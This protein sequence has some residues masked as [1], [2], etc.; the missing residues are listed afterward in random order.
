MIFCKS[1]KSILFLLVLAPALAICQDAQER[2]L[3]IIDSI[4]VIEDPKPGHSP[5]EAQI[6][7]VSVITDKK[8]IKDQFGYSNIDKVISIRTKAFLERTDSVKRIPTTKL[9]IKR[10]GTWFLKDSDTPYTGYFIDYFLN[11]TKEGEGYFENGRAK[12]LRT[13][14][15]LNGYKRFTRNYQNG[16]EN[17][18]STEYF[19]N[20]NVRMEGTT[21]GGKENG[22]WK[23]WYSTGRLKRE[24]TFS[25]GNVDV[26]KE[27]NKFYN[28]LTNGINQ[29]AAGNY[30]LA[31]KTL[32]K[33]EELNS[34]YSDLYFHRG[35]AFFMQFK[36][37]QAIADYD[38]ALALE[39]LYKE[40]LTNRAFARIRKHE[41]RDSRTLS[42]T[43][44]TTVIA[45]KS[46]TTIPP[47]DVEKICS[48]LK[49]GIDLGDI[50]PMIMDALTK[51]CK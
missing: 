41:F 28:K 50:S 29:S 43:S 2:L 16:I 6:G 7:D 18:V 37:D 9:M 49:L 47:N 25:D 8:V 11:G 40:V 3:Y 17:G 24:L 15:Y 14:Y 22:L 21:R 31:I 34:K 5:T 12:G 1:M 38:K 27:D 44:G 46:D 42:K 35:T 36:F 33:A 20:G 39:P 19:M 45:T 10:N 4:P 26:A 51:Y 48:D 23:E 30:D 13:S 32:S